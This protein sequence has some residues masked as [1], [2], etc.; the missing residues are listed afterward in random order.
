MVLL[1]G[2]YVCFRKTRSLQLV[3]SVF[4]LFI[5]IFLVSFFFFFFFLVTWTYII[6]YGVLNTT[7]MAVS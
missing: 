7:A 5:I 4:V 3:R 1:I 6:T 2:S